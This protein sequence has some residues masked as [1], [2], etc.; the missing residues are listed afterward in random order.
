MSAVGASRNGEIF[1]VSKS[2][3]ALSWPVYRPRGWGAPTRSKKLPKPWFGLDT[4]R[5]V[6][7]PRK[8]G[9]FVCGWAVGESTHQFTSLLDLEPATYFIWNLGYDIEGMLRDLD[10]E[11]AWAARADGASFELLGGRAIYYHG[12]RFNWQN[13]AKGKLTFIEA[14]SF[15][16]RVPLSKIG[17]KIGIDGSRMSLDKYLRDPSAFLCRLS[18]KRELTYREAVD[19]YCQQDARI[20]YEAI[21]NLDKGVQTLGVDLA[22]T[23]GGTARRFLARM[24]PFPKLLWQTHKAFLRSYGGGRF[25]VTKR[26]VLFDVNQYDLVSAYPA[27]LAKCPWL[28]NSAVARMTRRFSDHALYGTYEIGFKMPGEYLGIAPRWRNGIRVYSKAQERTWLARPEVEWLIRNG[29]PVTIH[30]GLEVFDENATDLW[31][32]VIRELFDLKKKGGTDGLGAKIVLNSQ[33]GV[34][35]QLVRR[36]GEWVPIGAAENPVDF[37]GLLALEEAPKEFEGGKYYAPLYS[38]DLTSR[39]RTWLMD[40]G[41]ELGRENY[42]GGHTDSA[43]G[44]G[45]IT[46]NVG[47]ELGQWKLEKRADVANVRGTG[48]YAMDDS[49]K[50]RGITRKG[51]PEQLWESQHERRTRVGIKS[52]GTWDEVSVIMPKMVANNFLIEQK[53]EWPVPLTLDMVKAR[54]FVDSEALAEV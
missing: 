51:R 50:F 44:H 39:T 25:E 24:G 37:A 32:S 35:I 43:L 6:L 40:A 17:Q 29:F 5:N 54:R 49:V 48:L 36:N 45:R 21:I 46:R 4:E 30:R 52:A 31:G 47:P 19:W 15:F 8:P 22:A 18:D 2:E 9:E 33:Y 16:G 7:A 38:G 27:A 14:S 41:M 12:K 3:L 13:P 11:E 28:T 20:V 10:V 34:L 26:G 42:I 23:P 53:R 1:V